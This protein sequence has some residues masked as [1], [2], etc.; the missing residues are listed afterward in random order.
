MTNKPKI[1]EL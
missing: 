1:N